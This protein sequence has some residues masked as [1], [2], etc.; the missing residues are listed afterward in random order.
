M[1]GG[2]ILDPDDTAAGRQLFERLTHKLSSRGLASLPVDDR[3]PDLNLSLRLRRRVD[4]ADVVAVDDGAVGRGHVV[5]CFLPGSLRRRK[6][7]AQPGLPGEGA[8]HES[9]LEFRMCCR[10]PRSD[11]DR[12]SE[13]LVSRERGQPFSGNELDVPTEHPIEKKV[14]RLATGGRP[15]PIDAPN[16]GRHRPVPGRRRAR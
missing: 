12:T 10:R 3:D 1:P 7:E 2:G 8:G 6:T 16:K 13:D 11:I 5:T 4:P 15:A 14:D 9:A